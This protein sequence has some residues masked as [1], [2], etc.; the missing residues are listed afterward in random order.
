MATLTGFCKFSELPK[1]LQRMVWERAVLEDNKDRIVP[2]AFDTERIVLTHELRNPS[3]VFKVCQLARVAATSLY[4]KRIPMV[5]F[6]MHWPDNNVPAWN[7]FVKVVDEGMSAEE[8][9]N[10]GH[11]IGY[12]CISTQLDVFLV[13]RWHFTFKPRIF[14][15]GPEYMTT[16][17]P[18]DMLSQQE[19][20][21]EQE[22]DR[23]F[24][25]LRPDWKWTD[26]LQPQFD[27]KVLSAAQVCFRVPLEDPASCK[28][29]LLTQLCDDCSSQEV[30]QYP[31]YTYGIY[32]WLSFFLF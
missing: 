26:A 7:L 20:L 18:R 5:K 22:I 28:R 3:P 32:R 16:R 29:T 9:E 21:M 24:D 14:D 31:K 6:H 27:R 12:V 1:E 4:D 19:R 2:V 17:L 13:S 11:V 23:A 8:R 10:D 30:L 25:H 15:D